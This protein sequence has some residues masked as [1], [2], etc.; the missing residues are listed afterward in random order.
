MD[1]ISWAWLALSVSVAYLYNKLDRIERNN[2]SL[3]CIAAFMSQT[4][5]YIRGLKGDEIDF[6]VDFGK[7][8]TLTLNYYV[9]GLTIYVKISPDTSW[10]EVGGSNWEA[11]RNKS[12]DVLWDVDR[13][14]P[15]SQLTPSL[16]DHVRQQCR[17]G[18]SRKWDGVRTT[19]YYPPLRSWMSPGEDASYPGSSAKAFKRFCA[20]S[21]EARYRFNT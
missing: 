10:F 8:P 18:A 6:Y 9:D 14:G 1:H 3:G 12:E 4:L 2:Q 20:L 13:Y 7:R 19:L 17:D 21:N 15:A 5:P 11:I 16:I